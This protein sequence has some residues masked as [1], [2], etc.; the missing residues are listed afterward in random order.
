MQAGT[1]EA[2]GRQ[3][4]HVRYRRGRDHPRRAVTTLDDIARER[5]ASVAGLGVGEGTL[6]EVDATVLVGLVE[7]D[8]DARVRSAALGALVRRSPSTSARAWERA[9]FDGDADVRR[10]AAETAPALGARIPVPALARLLADDDTWVAESAAFALGERADAA[11]HAVPALAAAATGHADALVREAAIAALGALGDPRGL[12]AVLTG[13]HDKPPIRRRAVLAL[14][15]FEGAEVEEQLQRALGD[16]DWQVR[17]AA[18][19]L[20]RVNV[21]R[22]EP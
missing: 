2:R 5:A 9:A 17:Q 20:M 19:D 18:E 4:T 16:P 21:R 15:A 14:A 12:P 8:P 11:A 6:P 1:A 10:R 13:C 7:Q 22:C 3:L